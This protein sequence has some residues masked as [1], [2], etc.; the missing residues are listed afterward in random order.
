MDTPEDFKF[1]ESL[2]ETDPDF[3]RAYLGGIKPEMSTEDKTL[4]IRE[5]ANIIDVCENTILNHI[6]ANKLKAKFVDNRWVVK[7]SDFDTYQSAMVMT[8]ARDGRSIIGF[9]KKSKKITPIKEEKMDGQNVYEKATSRTVTDFL[10]T[11][12]RNRSSGFSL[13][14]I[15]RDFNQ[16]STNSVTE[17]QMS[18]ILS[19]LRKK[20]IVIRKGKGI[21]QVS[22]SIVGEPVQEKAHGQTPEAIA[23]IGSE[24]VVVD[25]DIESAQAA[26]KKHERLAVEAYIKNHAE[27]DTEFSFTIADVSRDYPHLKRVKIGKACVNMCQYGKLRKGDGLGEYIRPGRKIRVTSHAVATTAPSK[28]GS[29]NVL[30][31]IN[32]I[33]N[34]NMAADLKQKLIKNLMGA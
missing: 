28:S 25:A 20:G 8:K 19:T 29:N 4:S 31:E 17:S 6:H 26:H 9:K 10:H 21:Y 11:W 23:A 24:W 2:E 14:T 16:I 12:Q 5:C 34:S 3:V 27:V 22:P 18:G 13:P 33:V 1:L 7:K 30:D 15:C 32:Q